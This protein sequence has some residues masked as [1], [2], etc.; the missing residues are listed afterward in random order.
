[1]APTEGFVTI[2]G[3]IKESIVDGPGI[4]LVVF[5]QGCPHACPGCHNPHTHAYAGGNTVTL[6]SIVNEVGRNP[7]L[8][9]VTWSG[10]EPFG[11]AEAFAELTRRVKA[12]GKNVLT[13]TGYTFEHILAN[14][15]NR[16]GWQ[17]LLAGS[18]YLMDGKFVEERR[19]YHLLFRGSD[20]QR[21]IDVKESLRCGAA[22]CVPEP[23]YAGVQALGAAV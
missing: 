9:G 1:M 4:R 13:Y 23:E 18:D 10:G 5:A 21:F 17:E 22:V 19:S 6:D 14:A 11:Q 16:K 3:I 12:L 20:N 7:L 2:A 15:P 8:K